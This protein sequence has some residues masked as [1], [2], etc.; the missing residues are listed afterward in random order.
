MRSQVSRWGNSLAVRLPQQIVKSAGLKEGETLELDVAGGVVHL[1]P[2]RPS[3]SLNQLLAG[4][5]KDNLPDESFD[6]GP[7]GRELL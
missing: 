7:K 1:R 2:A 3:Y 6:D 4:I 5:T